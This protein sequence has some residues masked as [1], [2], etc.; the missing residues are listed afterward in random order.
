MTRNIIPDENKEITKDILDM[1]GRAHPQYGCLAYIVIFGGFMSV[2]G[3]TATKLFNNQNNN[4][5]E[6]SIVRTAIQGFTN[7]PAPDT[8]VIN[9]DKSRLPLNADDSAFIKKH[10]GGAFKIQTR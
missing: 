3:C 7:K 2:V 9:V 1:R 10:V 5:T 4:E 6:Q 8:L